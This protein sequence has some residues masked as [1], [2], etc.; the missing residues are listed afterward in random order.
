MC[1]RDRNDPVASIVRRISGPECIRFQ[2]PFGASLG[3]DVFLQ[4]N[5]VILHRKISDRVD[6]GLA[7][8]GVENEPVGATSARQG[9]LALFAEEIVVAGRANQLVVPAPTMQPVMISPAIDA[10]VAAI[11]L[12]PVPAGLTYDC[13]LYTSPSPRDRQKSRMPSSA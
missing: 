11:A 7:W 12:D 8:S 6:I 9:I 4:V 10:I 2:S 5:A 3:E 13:L 1:I